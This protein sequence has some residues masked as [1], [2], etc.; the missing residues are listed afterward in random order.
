VTVNAY[1]GAMLNGLLSVFSSL[2]ASFVAIETFIDSY[3][4]AIVVLAVHPVIM[5]NWTLWFL[6]TLRELK[7]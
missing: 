7:G 5:F 6:R 2:L 1:N 3:W 4:S